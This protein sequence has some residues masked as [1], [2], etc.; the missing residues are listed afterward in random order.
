MVMPGGREAVLDTASGIARAFCSGALD[1][2]YPPH[3]LVCGEPGCDYLCAACTEEITCVEAPYCRKCG[4]PCESFYCEACLDRE[5]AFERACSAGL[6]E[7]VLREAIHALKYDLRI[8]MA[9][10]LAELMARSFPDT[11]LGAKVDLVIAV[12]IHRKR[13]MERG[14]NQSAELSRIFC[15]RVSLPLES[16]VL[17]KSRETRHQ[18]DLPHDLRA[19]NVAGAFSVRKAENIMGR[20]VLLIDDVFTTG[21]TLNEVAKTLRSAGAGAVYAYTLARSM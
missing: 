1:L 7:G 19:I 13:M 17:Y 20:K 9:Q 14:F 10:P 5:F 6:F 16:G 15:K 21:S 4:I 3:C 8:V 18:V 2:V 12:P 11:R